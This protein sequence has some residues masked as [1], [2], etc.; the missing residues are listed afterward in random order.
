MQFWPAGLKQSG[1]SFSV[2]DKSRSC[3][4]NV[5]FRSVFGVPVAG[6]YLDAGVDG[7]WPEARKVRGT[8]PCVHGNGKL[9]EGMGVLRRYSGDSRSVDVS[10][11][12][13]FFGL[14]V[15]LVPRS[16]RVVELASYPMTEPGDL[17][18]RRFAGSRTLV[19]HG[20]T[21]TGAKVFRGASS[22]APDIDPFETELFS[23][24]T[25]LVIST[26]CSALR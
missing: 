21:P 20:F 3:A 5:G 7:R 4:P 12:T 16:S 22:V 6:R 1:F 15:A 10:W 8:T 9:G 25:S 26:L 18:Y 14:A 13:L 2:V 24:D 11:T 17:P 23:T 19:M